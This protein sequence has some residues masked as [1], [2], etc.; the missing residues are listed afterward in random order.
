MFAA[1]LS[2]RARPAWID[3]VI[4]WGVTIGISGFVA[5]LLLEE[6][7]L[8]RTFT[9]ILGATLLLAIA[10]HTMGLRGSATGAR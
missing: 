2:E 4:F 5:A 8:K 1:L 10:V 9:P 6:A 7:M 3:H